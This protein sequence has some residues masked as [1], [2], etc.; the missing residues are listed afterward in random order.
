M[1]CNDT[2]PQEFCLISFLIFS[3]SINITVN[4]LVSPVPDWR[5]CLAHKQTA[6]DIYTTALC[7]K[8]MSDVQLPPASMLA[9][10]CRYRVPGSNHSHM[11]PIHSGH[12]LNLIP[13]QSGRFRQGNSPV[14]QR[15]G[16]ARKNISAWQQSNYGRS[17]YFLYLWHL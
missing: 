2:N 1:F 6:L 16:H 5:A 10:D 3:F 11:V 12:L 15:T 13:H 17:I 8:H 4:I 9:R 7:S 14:N